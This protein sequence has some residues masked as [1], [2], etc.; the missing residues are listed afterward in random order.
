MRKPDVM[1]SITGGHFLMVKTSSCIVGQKAFCGSDL[2]QSGRPRTAGIGRQDVHEFRRTAKDDAV[3]DWLVYD[4]APRHHG[5]VIVLW[6]LCHFYSSL[7][8]DGDFGAAQSL[9]IAVFA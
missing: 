6:R 5:N 9:F 8:V 1:A 2:N 4:L 3:I 7:C